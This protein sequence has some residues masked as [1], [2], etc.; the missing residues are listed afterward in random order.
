MRADVATTE[1]AVLCQNGGPGVGPEVAEPC[2]RL[3]R[4]MAEHADTYA[5]RLVGLA[6][7]WSWAGGDEDKRRLAAERD[8]ITAASLECNNAR[9]A[10]IE[11]LNRDAASRDAARRSEAVALDDAA[12]LDEPATCAKLV[13]R[14][15]AAR[16]I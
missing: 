14:A 8:R 3:S 4:A 12:S 10:M 5:G 11:G 9:L 2:R 7:A 1:A 13:A 15:K 6:L 16:L